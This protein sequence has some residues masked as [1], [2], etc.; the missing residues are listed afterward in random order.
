M[1]VENSSGSGEE[2]EMDS[3]SDSY[4]KE[5]L[6]DEPGHGFQQGLDRSLGPSLCWVSLSA[7]LE[8]SGVNIAHCGLDLLGSRDPHI[9]ASKTGSYYAAQ[10]GLEVLN[11]SDSSALAPTVMRSHYIAQAGLPK[12]SSSLAQRAGITGL[13]L[14]SKLL[15]SSSPPALASRRA[16]IIGLS[17]DSKL[18]DSSSPPALASQSAGITG[19]NHCI[20]FG[21]NLFKVLR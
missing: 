12:Q 6:T 15:D 20:H 21:N 1:V 14:D 7:R 18:L 17:L 5:A 4:K 9:S 8:C 19:M 13:N 3:G 10:A 2:E 16:G 11:S